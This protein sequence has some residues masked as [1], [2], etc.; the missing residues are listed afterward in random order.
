MAHVLPQPYPTP[1]VIPNKGDDAGAQHSVD[2][3]GAGTY[4]SSENEHSGSPVLNEEQTPQTKGPW[5]Q[6]IK[7]KQFWITLLL[8]QGM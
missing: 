1:G 3:T 5:F 8:G 4:V 7:T 6:Y 2:K